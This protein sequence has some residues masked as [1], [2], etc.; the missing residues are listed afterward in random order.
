MRKKIMATY[1]ALDYKISEKECYL[2]FIDYELVTKRDKSNFSI[3][4]GIVSNKYRDEI[5]VWSNDAINSEAIKDIS[6]K[7][8][9]ESKSLDNLSIGKM[10]EESLTFKKL[11]LEDKDFDVRMAFNGRKQARIMNENQNNSLRELMKI[12]I[13]SYGDKLDF[14]NENY[15]TKLNSTTLESLDNPEINPH[16]QGILLKLSYNLNILNGNLWN[17]D[18]ENMI[19]VLNSSL[20]ILALPKKYYSADDLFLI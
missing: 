10:N 2:P 5:C 14:M 13:Y 19:K 17:A 18:V 9:I 4:L 12:L 3:L 6:S 11:M 15:L 8:T 20:K 1:S 16:I 7:F